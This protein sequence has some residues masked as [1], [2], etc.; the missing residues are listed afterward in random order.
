MQRWGSQSGPN[1]N[2]FSLCDFYHRC[3]I[4]ATCEMP[5]C[6]IRHSVL[7][8]CGKGRVYARV[9]FLSLSSLSPR[10]CKTGSSLGRLCL[11]DENKVP[12]NLLAA[13]IKACIVSQST[14]L[15][16]VQV[17]NSYLWLHIAA[18]MLTALSHHKTHTLISKPTQLLTTCRPTL[19]PYRSLSLSLTYTFHRRRLCPK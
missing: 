11:R 6:E 7:V 10:G 3:T 14:F 9:V 15:I 18:I 5:S 12:S 4:T 8:R 13:R 2:V 16:W 19:S 17:L 1:T